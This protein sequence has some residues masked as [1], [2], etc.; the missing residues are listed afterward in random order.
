MNSPEEYQRTYYRL[1]EELK[2][3]GRD[4]MPYPLTFIKC[5]PKIIEKE[6]T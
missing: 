3:E 4:E 1:A 6:R 2:P 5:P